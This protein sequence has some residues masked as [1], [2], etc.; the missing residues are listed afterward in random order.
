MS[1]V[2]FSW[3]FSAFPDG[4]FDYTLPMPRA[5]RLGVESGIF[6]ITHRCHNRA[7]L[8]K[9]AKDREGYRTKM[10]MHLQEFEVSLLDYCLTCNHVHLLVEA[11][12]R[13]EVS[14]LMRKVAGEFACSYNRRKGRQNAYWGDNF[15][16]TLVDSGDYLWRCLCYIEL[17]MVRCGV[18]RHPGEWDWVGYHEIMGHRQRYRL[19]D[20]ERLCWRLGTDRMEDVRRNLAASLGEAIAQEAMKREA[21]WT[22]SMAVGSR[23]FLEKTQ[24]LILSSRE[25]E[26]VEA[27]PDLWIL[28]ETKIPYRTKFRA[29]NESKIMIEAAN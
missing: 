22:E 24:P 6:H 15:H 13:L 17:N 12:D 14:G 11:Q 9:F 8:L 20:L 21:H 1:Y 7:L 2:R 29:K 4:F 25:T 3:R 5:H 10:R 27:T 26:I 28:K 23:E 16:A 19:L 18:V